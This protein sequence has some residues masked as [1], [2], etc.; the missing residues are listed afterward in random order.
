MAERA[1]IYLSRWDVDYLARYAFPLPISRGI[2]QEFVRGTYPGWEWNDLLPALLA[3]GRFDWDTRALRGDLAGVLF[4]A[5]GE[6]VDDDGSLEYPA[7]PA[8]ERRPQAS[9]RGACLLWCGWAH[10]C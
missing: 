5:S 3:S 10:L 1:D 2:S 7:K 8:E 4:T 6:I 9:P